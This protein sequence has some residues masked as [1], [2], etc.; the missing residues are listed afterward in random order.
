MSESYTQ[1]KALY[2]CPV[3]LTYLLSMNLD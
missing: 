3:C 2:K 1:Y